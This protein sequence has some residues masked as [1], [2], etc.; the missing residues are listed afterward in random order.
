MLVLSPSQALAYFEDFDGYADGTS[1]GSLSGWAT[2]VSDLTIQDIGV[3]APSPDNAFRENGRGIVQ[4][5]PG[6]DDLT[7]IQFD[8]V[9][10]TSAGVASD[11]DSWVTLTPPIAANSFTIAF[12]QGSILTGDLGASLSSCGT[13][14]YGEILTVV[15]E[16]SGDTAT[17]SIEGSAG[18]ACGGSFVHNAS[19][20]AYQRVLFYQ[21][22]IGTYD[23]YFDNFYANEQPPPVPPSSVDIE[24]YSSAGGYDVRMISPV[25]TSYQTYYTSSSTVDA[26]FDVDLPSYSGTST[27][28]L[29]LAQYVGGGSLITSTYYS[30]SLS[31]VTDINAIPVSLDVTNTSNGYTYS[32]RLYDYAQSSDPVRVWPFNIRHSDYSYTEDSGY[33][34]STFGAFYGVTNLLRTKIVFNYI[35]DAYDAIYTFVSFDYESATNTVSPALAIN[36][37]DGTTTSISIFEATQDSIFTDVRD[38][39]FPFFRGVMWI[40]FIF[41]IYHWLTGLHSGTSE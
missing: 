32:V 34:S 12:E 35:F 33:S 36:N 2:V 25:L 4:Y 31:S 8:V 24:S 5:F 39:A 29:V 22:E 16:V 15:V 38:F 37:G 1:V 19:I 9:D 10:Q 7:Y 27:T 26:L 3:T 14:I 41:G 21:N 6:T 28:E 20:G 23:T 40:G 11:Y 18:S 30:V 13:Y 17:Y